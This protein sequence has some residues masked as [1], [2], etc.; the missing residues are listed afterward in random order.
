LAGVIGLAMK[1]SMPAS[2]QASRWPSEE[3][4]EVAIRIVRRL[5]G[6]RARKRAATSVPFIPGRLQSRKATS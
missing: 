2:R 4:A 5:A 6:S 3:W 1:A